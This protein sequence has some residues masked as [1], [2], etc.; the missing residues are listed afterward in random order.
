MLFKL[1]RTEGLIL[2]IEISEKCFLFFYLELTT[3]QFRQFWGVW[4]FFT[5]CLTVYLYRYILESSLYINQITLFLFTIKSVP[6]EIIG[7]FFSPEPAIFS[8]SDK[9]RVEF[10]G[11]PNRSKKIKNLNLIKWAKNWNRAKR[12]CHTSFFVF[13]FFKMKLVPMKLDKNW[14]KCKFWERPIYL[15]MWNFEN[16]L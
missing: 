12:K 3:D 16:I 5:G 10:P 9:P 14:K 15:K 13:D 6:I 2:N 7:W 8:A 4:I 1:T 11:V